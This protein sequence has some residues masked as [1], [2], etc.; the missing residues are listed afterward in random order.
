MAPATAPAVESMQAVAPAATAAPGTA[1]AGM[2]TGAGRWSGG[3]AGRR[4]FASGLALA[5]GLGAAGGYSLGERRQLQA[6][7]TATTAASK[8]QAALAAFEARAIGTSPAETA[9]SG[10]AEEIRGMRA[11]LETLRGVLPRLAAAE[12]VRAL[13]RRVTAAIEAAE[14]GRVQQA[15]ALA[16]VIDRIDQAATQAAGGLTDLGARMGRLDGALVAKAAPAEPSSTASIVKSHP[17]A[18]AR[19]PEHPAEP[20][21]TEAPRTVPGWTV[22]GVFNGVALLEGP[23]GVYE[24]MRGDAL[25]GL[26]RVEAIHRQGRGWTVVTSRGSIGQPH[27]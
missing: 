19:Q 11:E 10:L 15:V 9:V 8:S 13:D 2:P 5:L 18:D 6:A 23:H 25:P 7:A 3:L 21:K 20:P 22:R 27:R 1:S 26:G 17:R 16:G 12:D 4:I 14:T 24:A